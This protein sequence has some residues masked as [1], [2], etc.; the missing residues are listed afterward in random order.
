MRGDGTSEQG[1][2][3]NNNLVEQFQIGMQE[4]LAFQTAVSKGEIAATKAETRENAAAAASG[5]NGK[6]SKWPKVRSKLLALEEDDVQEVDAYSSEY[7][8]KLMLLLI[9][10]SQVREAAHLAEVSKYEAEV[11]RAA[12][13]RQHKLAAE[14]AYAA[15]RAGDSDSGD[16]GPAFCTFGTSFFAGRQYF[17]DSPV[18]VGIEFDARSRPSCV[19]EVLVLPA[20]ARNLISQIERC[21]CMCSFLQ[22][23]TANLMD[24]GACGSR[25]GPKAIVKLRCIKANFGTEWRTVGERND[26]ARGLTAASMRKTSGMDLVRVH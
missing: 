20:L 19:K 23:I 3:H 6:A 2:W 7:I 9:E 4:L 1:L 15:A 26:R 25:L 13:I 24:L 11:K 18:N 17:G 14:A 5:G 12:D 10:N 22:I 8:D 16:D 21:S